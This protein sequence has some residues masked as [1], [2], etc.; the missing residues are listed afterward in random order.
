MKEG[1]TC[2]VLETKFPFYGSFDSVSVQMLL[3]L[4]L[5]ELT[6]CYYLPRHRLPSQLHS[7][8]LEPLVEG[9]TLIEYAAL[10]P[11]FSF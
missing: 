8:S 10:P 2:Y 9:D 5:A 1:P 4:K 11:S 7:L 3:R 6:T